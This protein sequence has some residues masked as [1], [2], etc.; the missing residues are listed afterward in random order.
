MMNNN[1]NYCLWQKLFRTQCNKKIATMEEK[2]SE[3]TAVS[4]LEKQNAEKEPAPV[5]PQVLS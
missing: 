1:L 5:A 4:K 3:K 2:C